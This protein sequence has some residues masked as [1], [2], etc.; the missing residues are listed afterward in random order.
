MWKVSIYKCFSCDRLFG[1]WFYEIE[2]PVYCDYKEMVCVEL[3]NNVILAESIDGSEA[4]YVKQC[5]GSY[6]HAEVIAKDRYDEYKA[7]PQLVYAGG[8][9][10]LKIIGA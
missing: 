1:G 8:F 9:I 2:T 10:D 6:V 5:D 7:T 4:F 3:P